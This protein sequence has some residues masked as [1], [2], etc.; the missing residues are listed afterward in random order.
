MRKRSDGCAMT[1][2]VVQVRATHVTR[3]LESEADV[4]RV[5]ELRSV[6]AASYTSGGGGRTTVSDGLKAE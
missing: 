1:E 2:V 5:P 4:V 3:G 6:E